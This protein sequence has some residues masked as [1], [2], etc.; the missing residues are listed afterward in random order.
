M[1]E[2]APGPRERFV[3]MPP[4]GNRKI[5]IF[6]DAKRIRI[7]LVP[8]K[9]VFKDMRSYKFMEFLIIFGLELLDTPGGK[10]KLQ[11]SKSWKCKLCRE[12]NS[13]LLP[14]LHHPHLFWAP[15]L[16][17]SSSNVST[18]PTIMAWLQIRNFWDK[19]L[20]LLGAKKRMIMFNIPPENWPSKNERII[21]Q[22]SFFRGELLNFVS[23]SMQ[24]KSNRLYQPAAPAPIIWW[25][26]SAKRCMF[27]YAEK[28]VE[29]VCI[30]RNKQIHRYPCIYIQTYIHIHF[31]NMCIYV[32]TMYIY[33][34]TYMF[35]CTIVYI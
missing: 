6:K 7:M 31:T 16:V 1:E 17:F 5:I 20:L 35:V 12:E 21:F 32:H 4:N 30:S 26:L 11:Y 25:I 18:F 9:L 8:R 33:A 2:S 13:K 34:Y 23:V 27:S 24:K 28:H 15:G 10:L 19:Q 29:K 22:P 3:H 14:H